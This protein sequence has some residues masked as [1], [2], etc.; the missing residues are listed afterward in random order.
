MR[1][2]IYNQM[3]GR[4]TTSP[5]RL[6]SDY[7]IVM[8]RSE[9]IVVGA[10]PA[11]IVAAIAARRLGLQVAVLDARTPPI[12]KPCGEG[13]LPQGVAALKTLSI[14]LPPESA[15]LFRGISFVD[16]EH[17]ARADFAGGSG[18][19]VRRTKLHRH[20]VNYAAGEGVEFHWGARVT[21]IDS[22]AVTTAKEKFPYRWLI[23]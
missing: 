4:R 3:T 8:K 18:Y 9:V 22:E 1:Q 10:G 16:E 6:A 23:G 5:A 7:L 21:Q 19:S 14:P 12:D 20:L 13:I 2:F 15:F 11:G 17:S